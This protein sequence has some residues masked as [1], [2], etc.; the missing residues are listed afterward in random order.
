MAIE[1]PS[2][3]ALERRLKELEKKV[4]KREQAEETL[5]FERTLL[6]SVMDSLEGGVYVS[7]IDTYEIL[8]ASQSAKD[9]FKKDIIGGVCYKEL[10][11]LD[12]PCDF[13]TNE[14]I[15][16][17][18]PE[19]HRWEIHNP[20][21]NKDYAIVDRVIKWPDGRDVRLEI[22]LDITEKK[23]SEEAFRESNEKYRNVFEN[24]ALSIILIDANGQMLDINPYHI[25]HIGRG[26]IAKENLVGH[27]LFTHPTVVSSGISKE[28]KGVLE[29]NSIDIKEHYFPTTSGGKP[30]YFN[31]RAVPLLSDDG[32][33]GAVIISEDVTEHKRSKGRIRDLSQQLIKSQ[34]NER[35]RISQELHDQVAQDVSAIKINC[36]M[37]SKNELHSSEIKTNLSE[38]SDKLKDILK[39]VRNMSYDL[40]PPSLEKLGLIET[41]S[42][43]CKDF[44]GE[45]D[46]NVEFFSVGM[47]N[48]SLTFEAKI[49]L[50]RMV[51]ESLNNVRKHAQASHVSIKLISSFPNIIL[52]IEDDGKGFDTE[53]RLLTAHE[54]K[55]MGVHSMKERVRL[56]QGE[57][58]IVSIPGKGTM[59]VFEIP[60]RDGN[61]SA[62]EKVTE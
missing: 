18:R 23:K 57:M 51:Q 52:R 43:Y 17:K 4:K 62:S 25:N 50:Y 45:N 24:V 10:Q 58:R 1:K 61:I 54:E 46:I 22:A 42:Q 8:Y 55:R 39:T 15:L 30:A 60:Y 48:L 37:L 40:R 44:S 13:C 20:L 16:K 19:P 47:D 33:T 31:T 12:S 35:Q 28:M 59:V 29:G 5:A 21:L 3:E 14:I 26:R 32:V 56:L 11:G 9:A 7:D 53:T 2:Y 41:I 6:H 36:E 27:N 49:N 38:I 34:E